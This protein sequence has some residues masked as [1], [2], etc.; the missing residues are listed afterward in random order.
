MHYI[1]VE[2]CYLYERINALG[3]VIQ[4]SQLNNIG[5]VI[6]VTTC[7]NT[8]SRFY[9]QRDIHH[10]TLEGTSILSITHIRSCASFVLRLMGIS[11]RQFA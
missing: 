3:D 2:M 8:D 10:Y 1:L 7:T 4:K 6:Y 9:M 5:V 11:F